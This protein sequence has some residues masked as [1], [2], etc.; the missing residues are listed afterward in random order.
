MKPLQKA[1]VQALCVL[2]LFLVACTPVEEPKTA[3]ISGG[4]YTD[5][6]KNAQWENTEEGIAAMSVRL[7]FGAC[8][9]NLLQ[10][11]LTDDKGEFI[12]TDLAPGEYCVYPD[13]EL[14][15]CGYAGNSP[16]TGITRHVTLESG[17]K[18]DLVWFGFGNLSGSEESPAIEES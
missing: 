3:S 14:Q 10:T 1:C 9:E 11:H 6:D 7:Y 15:T 4:I 5:C 12:F 16:T 17:T 18:A 8:G 13:F 2:P